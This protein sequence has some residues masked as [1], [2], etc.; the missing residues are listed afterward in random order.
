MVKAVAIRAIADKLMSAIRR[1]SVIENRSLCRQFRIDELHPLVQRE[2]SSAHIHHQVFIIAEILGQ[3]SSRDAGRRFR[4]I[5]HLHRHAAVIHQL[6]HCIFLSISYI[7]SHAILRQH[8]IPIV[9]TLFLSNGRNRS[10]YR[11]PM[12]H[13]ARN[14]RFQ[15]F[16]IL[17]I[18]HHLRHRRSHASGGRGMH[19]IIFRTHI[20]IRCALVPLDISQEGSH[21]SSRLASSSL[22]SSRLLRHLAMPS[23]RLSQ[24]FERSGIAQFYSGAKLLI[25]LHQVHESLRQLSLVV[26]PLVGISHDFGHSVIP[27]NN[28]ESPALCVRENVIAF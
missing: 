5:I 18:S 10:S 3:M 22:G 23:L 11:I 15:L 27:R 12:A 16:W 6:S 13:V 8:V 2:R 20:I 1:L 24:V 26:R 14:I 21:G 19:V 28:G 17:V 9:D 25:L 7:S 4:T